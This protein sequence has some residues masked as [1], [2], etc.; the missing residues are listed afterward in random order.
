MSLDFGLQLGGQERTRELTFRALVEVLLALGAKMA[1][2]PLQDRLQD[3]FWNDFSPN[4][5]PFGPSW[6]HFD[7]MLDRFLVDFWLDF[8]R[9]LF[10]FYMMFI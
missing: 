3:Q 4:W 8:D 9:F 2:R 6:T 5:D 7:P 10:D 1:P